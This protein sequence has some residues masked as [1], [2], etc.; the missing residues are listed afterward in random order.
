MTGWV[1]KI[2]TSY[3]SKGGWGE[4]QKLLPLICISDPDWELAIKEVWREFPDV[5]EYEFLVNGT[6]AMEAAN[7]NRELLKMDRPR[8]EYNFKQL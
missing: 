8:K 6:K 4:K 3:I 1:V 5:D 2:S 7:N